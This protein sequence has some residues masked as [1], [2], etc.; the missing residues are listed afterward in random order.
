MDFWFSPRPRQPGLRQ[1][2]TSSYLKAMLF[3]RTFC[4]G[5]EGIGSRSDDGGGLLPTNP[6]S[7][8]QGRFVLSPAVFTLLL[9]GPWH[10]WVAVKELKLSYHNGYI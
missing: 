9:L 4:E 6:G 1:A 5:P 3:P 10:C 2:V 8:C 7:G